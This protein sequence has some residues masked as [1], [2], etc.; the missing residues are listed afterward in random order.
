MAPPPAAL[1]LVC[2]FAPPPVAATPNVAA[3]TGDDDDLLDSAWVERAT[4][5]PPAPPVT[6]LAEELMEPF[7]DAFAILP[8]LSSLVLVM[9]LAPPAL[10]FLPKIPPPPPP[11][12][13]AAAPDDSLRTVPASG[14]TD[15]CR[16]RNPPPVEL[17]PLL[18]PLPLPVLA[19]PRPTCT[20][21][22]GV[23]LTRVGVLCCGDAQDL[24]RARTRG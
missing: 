11:L 23:C 16:E 14:T 4:T 8:R 7:P 21:D 9:G 12:P 24:P 15:D 2:P 5:A 19:T 20:L 13:V 18:L 10:E 22:G 6:P 3:G 1:V 17:L